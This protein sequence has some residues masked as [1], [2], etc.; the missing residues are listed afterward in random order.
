[1]RTDHWNSNSFWST[2]WDANTWSWKSSVS[3]SVLFTWVS[4]LPPIVRG[5]YTSPN[6]CPSHSESQDKL[7]STPT[8]RQ[9]WS[10]N[11][12]AL[13]SKPP[14]LC[15]RFYPALWS[16]NRKWSWTFWR[17]PWFC[18]SLGAWSRKTRCGRLD[19]TKLTQ[20]ILHWFRTVHFQKS[21][22]IRF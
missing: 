15:N 14:F 21:A 18:W 6:W 8:V 7:P 2:I 11:S 5:S 20:K 16:A 19:S 3:K 9:T 12:N 4:R 13:A 10:L 1:M 17:T 22:K